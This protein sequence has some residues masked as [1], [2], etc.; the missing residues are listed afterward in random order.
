MD[1]GVAGWEDFG[2]VPIAVGSGSS[3]AGSLRARP[4]TGSPVRGSPLEDDGVDNS[5]SCGIP[6]EVQELGAQGVAE[7]TSK[8]HTVFTKV[9]TSVARE[10][11]AAAPSL[12][13]MLPDQ[14]SSLQL[15]AG[16]P[17]SPKP[18]AVHV[19]FSQ[20]VDYVPGEVNITPHG[21]SIRGVPMGIAF[22]ETLARSFGAGS[23]SCTLQAS[24]SPRPGGPKLPATSGFHSVSGAIGARHGPL[25]HLE[26]LEQPQAV[27]RLHLEITLQHANTI[28]KVSASELIPLAVG[29]RPFV[30]GRAAHP[31]V[32]RAISGASE[33]RR[34]AF[35]VPSDLTDAAAS[36][37]REVVSGVLSRSP[38]DAPVL[39]Q[40]FVLFPSL[41]RPPQ[42][43]RKD[44]TL[45]KRA[46]VE[47]DWQ[48]SRRSQLMLYCLRRLD[49]ARSQSLSVWASKRRF[50]AGEAFTLYGAEGRAEPTD[51][52]YV[53]VLKFYERREGPGPRSVLTLSR[54]G[55]LL[56]RPPGSVSGAVPSS[57]GP[58]EIDAAA[59]A[60]G[61][62]G[63]GSG[64]VPPDTPA[65]LLPPPGVGG[66]GGVGL[67]LSLGRQRTLR[68][69]Y[70]CV[71]AL[72]E[73]RQHLQ[74]LRAQSSDA[75]GNIPLPES[76]TVTWDGVLD[77]TL[78]YR[79]GVALRRLIDSHYLDHL[80]RSQETVDRV[81]KLAIANNDPALMMSLYEHT[82]IEMDLRVLA[83]LVHVWAVQP[84]SIRAAAAAAAGAAGGAGG[85]GGRGRGP[86]S[87]Y[88]ACAA[89]ANDDMAADY[90]DGADEGGNLAGRIEEFLVKYVVR[91]RN[92]L[93]VTAAILR[94]IDDEI[95][96]HEENRRIMRLA[97]A[98]FHSL[99]LAMLKRLNRYAEMR[100]IRFVERILQPA[101]LPNS[102]N[103][104]SPLQIAFES[105]D[106]KFMTETLIEL[107]VKVQWLGR[108]L[109][110]LTAHE[111][112]RAVGAT[113]PLLAYAVLK[114][115]GFAGKG[116]MDPLAMAASRLWHMYVFTSNAFFNSPRGRWCMHALFELVFLGLYQWQVMYP[117]LDVEQ[118]RVV[119][120]VFVCF[121]LGNLLDMAQFV[122]FR[123]GSLARLRKYLADPWNALSLVV[124]VGL[125]VLTSLKLAQDFGGMSPYKTADAVHMCMA[126]LA[127][128]VWVRALGMAVPVYPS[129]GP[130][131]NTVARMIEE[132]IAFLFPMLII[133]TGFS[134]MMT[135]I[136]QDQVTQYGS[137]I[138]SMLQ[139]FSSML[140]NFDFTLFSNDNCNPDCT[141]VQQVYGAVVQ[142]IFLIISAILLMNLLIAIITNRYRPEAVEA[143]TQFKKAQIVSYYQTQ[144]IRNLVCSPFCLPQLLLQSVPLL[145]AG[146]RPKLSGA[147]RG[148][149]ALGLV[150]LDGVVLPDEGS[151]RPTGA[152]EVPHLVF[153][154][155]LYPL[156]AALC[157]LLF[158]LYTP[159]A[160]VQFASK[161]YSRLLK[162]YVKRTQQMRRRGQQQQQQGKG[163]KAGESK[164]RGKQ[165]RRSEDGKQELLQ[166]A[167]AA[168]LETGGAA[169][170]AGGSGGGGAAAISRAS[171]GSLTS[172]HT[173]VSDAVKQYQRLKKRLQADA[174]HQSNVG[175]AHASGY[176]LAASVL[177]VVGLLFYLVVLVGLLLLGWSSLYQWAAKLAFSGHNIL[178]RPIADMAR[179]RRRWQRVSPGGSGSGSGSGSP[180]A[181]AA[182]ALHVA[183]GVGTEA[184]TAGGGRGAVP[185]P[186]GGRRT[187]SGLLGRRKDGDGGDGGGGGGSAAADGSTAGG[188]G[189]GFSRLSAQASR[190]RLHWRHAI[191]R[192]IAMKNERYLEKRDVLR[193]LAASKFKPH[194][195]GWNLR[196]DLRSSSQDILDSQMQDLEDDNDP[197][198]DDDALAGGAEDDDTLEATILD[199]TEN[200]TSLL[201]GGIAAQHAAVMA[202][203]EQVRDLA[204]QVARLRDGGA[205]AAAGVGGFGDGGGGST[206][207]PATVARPGLPATRPPSMWG[208]VEDGEAGVESF[209]ADAVC[210]G[211]GIQRELELELGLGR[212]SPPPPARRL[213]M[214]SASGTEPPPP[215]PEP[216]GG[217]DLAAEQEAEAAEAAEA[218]AAE[219]EAAAAPPP[220]L[221]S[222]ATP[223]RPA[224]ARAKTAPPRPPHLA[225]SPADRLS[226]GDGDSPPP[227]LPPPQPSHP[228]LAFTEGNAGPTPAAATAAPA[229]SAAARPPLPPGARAAAATASGGAS[230]RAAIG[231]SPA[232]PTHGSVRRLSGA[233]A[234]PRALQPQQ[235][236]ERLLNSSA[237]GSDALL[238]A[239]G[240]ERER[241]AAPAAAVAAAAGAPA[242]AAAANSGDRPSSRRPILEPIRS[243]GSAAVPAA[244]PLTAGPLPALTPAPEP[245]PAV[246]AAGG[247]VGGAPAPAPASADAAPAAS[248][249]AA[250]A[251]PSKAPQ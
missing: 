116:T 63:G 247:P 164:K 184:A 78:A 234:G 76:G 88:E 187:L 248:T 97:S 31:A 72:Q 23:G 220:P 181:A 163:E 129:L 57:G 208:L 240:T 174:P 16:A 115:M 122:H 215:P 185:V 25:H 93:S 238:A 32:I 50:G 133:L 211:S 81:E 175:L 91:R 152:A 150:P 131:L 130:L 183:S 155:T 227:P 94:A 241:A 65:G 219:A 77:Y 52:S 87:R 218:K 67:S 166:P 98:R 59:S 171:S 56:Q 243:G 156:M 237:G 151:D 61:F 41:M 9:P 230:S 108:E 42:W 224:R 209:D 148:V 231:G 55:P 193:C 83:F 199:K 60:S 82:T 145:P 14:P 27:A 69:G 159:F 100:S 92:P 10:L 242:A 73:V 4:N 35:Y 127:V 105:R 66:V 121:I 217:E 205:A 43:L 124:N 1:R 24:P 177:A 22:A 170:A 89:A 153:L 244:A 216:P 71:D 84:L 195:A 34:G 191:Q 109:L 3:R 110:A 53:L 188:G 36:G 207:P 95:A 250:A 197:W 79:D 15:S 104:V 229:S 30:N 203:A 111:D 135:A 186:V 26:I 246:V 144:V 113:N 80:L 11:S 149:T 107:Y 106:L 222:D 194:M 33:L 137:F 74:L 198:D 239:I 117:D 136:Y 251:V 132:V 141:D 235:T 13:V 58:G 47:V 167:A 226:A 29:E 202:L 180:A 45:V 249:S 221:A 6:G 228:S 8:P 96:T 90:Y 125:L 126:T 154:F 2:P 214:S 146:R 103:E 5:W 168:D 48:L 162:R 158:L 62:G 120:L 19:Q 118:L 212:D 233:G 223:P 196:A 189:D 210:M 134:T 192:V 40:L 28:E 213:S 165:V 201:K 245:A 44:F 12:T 206:T 21:A 128:F 37:G 75:S 46:V 68:P 51:R 70:T 85:R 49:L 178:L 101:E 18:S 176:L 114:S 86:A 225:V 7:S 204:E 142:V 172:H 182:A 161:M 160:V 147:A 140:G 236:L 112:P 17:P 119:H 54:D 64:G 38:R 190:A 169:A 20:P 123:Y 102:V 138:N 157:I 173:P 139:L 99:H 232:A 200:L 179:A 39:V 143:E